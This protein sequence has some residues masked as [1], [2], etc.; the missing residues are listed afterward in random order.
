[1]QNPFLPLSVQIFT[2]CL[3]FCKNIISKEL[4]HAIFGFIKLL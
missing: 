2:P 3:Q 4:L 1:M